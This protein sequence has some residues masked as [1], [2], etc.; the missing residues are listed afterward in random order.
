MAYDQ[1]IR[2]HPQTLIWQHWVSADNADGGYW[3]DGLMGN[4]MLANG[5]PIQSNIT[6]SDV[7]NYTNTVHIYETINN[8]N[9]Q[10]RIVDSSINSNIL[11]QMY[12]DIIYELIP[13][14]ESEIV[15]EE[16]LT[17]PNW[18]LFRPQIISYSL[19]EDFKIVSG[20]Y[21]DA[22]AIVYNPLSSSSYQ[23]LNDIIYTDNNINI[24]SG[25]I[26]PQSEL[27]LT[28]KLGT[29][30]LINESPYSQSG[31]FHGKLPAATNT[32]FRLEAKNRG[33]ITTSREYFATTIDFKNHPMFGRNLI[34]NPDGSTGLSKW[35]VVRGIPKVI[36]A[37]NQNT[38]EGW[39]DAWTAFKGSG[40]SQYEI[41]TL[42]N[43][44]NIIGPLPGDIGMENWKF[45]SFFTG[46]QVTDPRWTD[47]YY[48][49]D[50]T[51][52]SDII[53]RKVIRNTNIFG[54]L[55]AYLGGIGQMRFWKS[56]QYDGETLYQRGI[57]DRVFLK[58]HLLDEYDNIMNEHYYLWNP[59][60]ERY[61][62]SLYLRKV[63]FYIPKGTRKIR[64]WLNFERY[65]NYIAEKF[66]NLAGDV[67]YER[68]QPG[69]TLPQDRGYTPYF[70]KYV[71]MHGSAATGINLVLFADHYNDNAVIRPHNGSTYLDPNPSQWY[72]ETNFLAN[73]VI[74]KL[75]EVDPNE[76]DVVLSI[77]DEQMASSGAS[78]STGGTSAATNTSTGQ[79]ISSW[80]SSAMATFF[81]P[82]S[83][84][85][86]NLLKLSKDDVYA[87]LFDK[88]NELK[89][90]GI[91]DI[92]QQYNL[93]S[94]DKWFTY[95]YRASEIQAAVENNQ[96]IL[97]TEYNYR[98]S[99]NASEVPLQMYSWYHNINH[100]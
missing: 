11:Y 53:D 86:H 27:N 64:V 33:G 49:V 89:H 63:D 74:N 88:I 34:K 80:A 22:N 15:I 92:V 29:K 73:M 62:L 40:D 23:I 8:G 76:Q 26:Y 36:K 47:M 1:L 46:G 21:L 81:V 79:N 43:D 2:R 37:W 9:I 42:G 48:D 67:Y 56:S 100:I 50:L 41:N 87:S 10:N 78:T 4:A 84:I 52:I 93:I 17:P 75:D 24:T 71:F 97:D 39:G 38:G 77:I 94:S 45:E 60:H 54:S 18:Q 51:T 82:Q 16:L 91:L 98:I 12:D 70:D 96:Q 20:T 90:D 5:D 99:I 83:L 31:Y 57:F 69:H 14:T 44:F 85:P 7:T 3:V 68:L 28:W 13:P 6:Q 59:M 72:S 35:K 19:H 25:S 61:R 30:I 95:K 65:H 66:K 55:Y 58:A 32:V